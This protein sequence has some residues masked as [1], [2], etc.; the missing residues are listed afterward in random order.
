MNSEF[1]NT[2]MS[3]IFKLIELANFTTNQLYIMKNLFLITI[4][5]FTFS[6]IIAQVT[7]PPFPLSSPV[8]PPPVEEEVF[9]VVEEMPRFPGC[10]NKELNSRKK[11]EC[12]KKRM[13]EYIDDNLNYPKE[14]LDQ[15]IEGMAVIQ[16][17]IWKDRSIRDIKLVRDP[18][19]GTGEEAARIVES[20]KEM[21]E[22]WRAGHQRGRPVN[23]QYTL[24]VKFRL[25]KPS[26]KHSRVRSNNPFD[27]ENDIV[28]MTNLH[29]EPLFPDCPKQKNNDCTMESLKAF[30]N[31]NQLYPEKALENRIQGIVKMSFII[32]LDGSL[33][34]ISASGGVPKILRDDAIEIFKWM[35]QEDL[36][37]TPGKKNNRAIRT[38]YRCDVAYDI[39]EWEAR[40]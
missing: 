23:V 19:A 16:F 5:T 33:S 2:E 17:T 40:N 35:N 13:L 25:E 36:K 22:K 37:W 18:G 24:P 30:I 34:E 12:A 9:K 21:D 31:E 8:P 32:E 20:M 1:N 3:S 39:E 26:K 10:E 29:E 27:S 28:D 11:E 4:F 6:S 38:L 15:E 7:A 14:A